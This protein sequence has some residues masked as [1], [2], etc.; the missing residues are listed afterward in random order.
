MSACRYK[1]EV[2]EGSR[3]SARR[4]HFWRCG[5]YGRL[6]VSHEFFSEPLGGTALLQSAACARLSRKIDSQEPDD[7]QLQVQIFRSLHCHVQAAMSFANCNLIPYSD[8]TQVHAVNCVAV[9][10]RLFAEFE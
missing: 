9:A 10:G 4:L 7:V 3:R 8:V 6:A 1:N 5:A 2:S